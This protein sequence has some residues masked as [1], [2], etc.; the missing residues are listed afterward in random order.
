MLVNVTAVFPVFDTVNDIGP[1]VVPTPSSPNCNNVGAITIV[2]G[3]LV[4]N[5]AVTVLDAL[6]ATV[7]VGGFVCGLGGVQ[8]ELKLVNVEPLPATAVSTTLLLPANVAVQA[9]GQVIPAGALVTVPEPLTV[10]VNPAAPI[11]ERFT[12]CMLPAVGPLSVIVIVPVYAMN[13]VGSNATCN[14][15]EPPIASV[16]G[17]AG[18]GF[19]ASENAPVVIAM[20]EIASGASPELVSVTGKVALALIGWFENAAVAVESVTFGF[21]STF[22]TRLLYKSPTY[23]LPSAVTVTPTGVAMLAA[24]A[25]P[26]SPENPKR[27]APRKGRND[28]AGAVHAANP[29]V[30]GVRNKK[31]ARAIQRHSIGRIQRGA[32]GCAAVARVSSG[33]CA[34]NRGD[35]AR[36]ARINLAD[37]I[38]I[39]VRDVQVA[40]GVNV[41]AQRTIQSRADG[42]AAVSR[43]I[44]TLHAADGRVAGRAISSNSGDR[45]GGVYFADAIVLRIHEIKISGGIADGAA[46][47]VQARAQ[48][49]S[50]VAATGKGRRALISG[51][52]DGADDSCRAIYLANSVITIIRDQQAAGSFDRDGARLEKRSGRGRSAITARIRRLRAGNSGADNRGYGLAR[53][54]DFADAVVLRVHEKQI[55]VG[56]ER[57][58]AR[59]IQA[60]AGGQPAVTHSRRCR[61]RW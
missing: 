33:A 34:G 39:G 14:V 41:Q 46:R 40:G 29:V 51:S 12:V 30:A 53:G 31:V 6:I 48:R 43:K 42:R 32:G 18:Q 24:S 52:H 19:V 60:G 47:V 2:P 49:R 27:A 13:C 10:T 5:V 17:A 26:P 20:S 15:H 56:I 45:A 35:D 16:V 36:R 1:L 37:H 44:S 21:S 22:L 54:A 28:F 58:I 59:V 61:P 25:G 3:A 9:E 11:P 57:G 50:A 7:Q 23:I 38:V 8:F 55:A 4:V